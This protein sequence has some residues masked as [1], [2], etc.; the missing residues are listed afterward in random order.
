MIDRHTAVVAFVITFAAIPIPLHGRTRPESLQPRFDRHRDRTFSLG[1]DGWILERFGQDVAILRT[2]LTT[3]G[4]GSA[5]AGLL[6]LSCEA[7][8][9]R[10]R[11]SFSD[12]ILGDNDTARSGTVL[13][14]P[15]GRLGSTDF[16]RVGPAQIVDGR[17]LTVI[18][19]GLSTAGF[20]TTFVRLLKVGT[21]R[22]D[23]LIRSGPV[24]LRPFLFAPILPAYVLT[25]VV[26][27]TDLIAFD[28]F[29]ATC[30][31]PSK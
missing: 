15:S 22:L 5:A 24:A 29:L 25:P 17:V 10:W 31:A 27:L 1:R 26:R 13:L 3:S 6:V 20:V 21:D 19:N 23:L 30:T 12:R 28:D 2:N 11:L 8:M 4:A 7:G 14:R 9:G 16:S 18:D